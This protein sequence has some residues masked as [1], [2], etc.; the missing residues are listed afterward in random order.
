VIPLLAAFN[1]L[2]QFGVMD[3]LVVV[4]VVTHGDSSLGYL[5]EFYTKPEKN[6]SLFL[7]IFENAPSA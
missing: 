5:L 7:L 3:F 2:L 6:G 4:M 1:S